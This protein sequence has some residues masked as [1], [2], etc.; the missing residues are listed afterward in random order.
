MRLLPSLERVVLH[1]KIQK[2]CGFLLN[3]RIEFLAAEGLIDVSDAALE[4][5]SPSR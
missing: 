3:R 4:R 2:H 5:V 1:H